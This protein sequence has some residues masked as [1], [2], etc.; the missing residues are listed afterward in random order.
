MDNPKFKVEKFGEILTVYLGDEPV[1]EWIRGVGK[2]ILMPE[3]L[4]A[5]ESLIR[6]K[7]NTK[8]CAVIISEINF[9]SYNYHISV[10]RSSIGDTL[11]KIMEW[12]L[13]REEYEMCARI[14][15][16]YELL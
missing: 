8:L 16:L 4:R 7:S 10:K 2:S 12:A 15:K 5:C 14:K 3:L 6:G 11:D 1:E 13:D 9:K